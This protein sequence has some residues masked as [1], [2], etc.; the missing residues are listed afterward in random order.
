MQRDH[1]RGLDEIYA[2]DGMR[3]GR[4]EYVDVIDVSRCGCHFQ[5]YTKCFFQTTMDADGYYVIATGVPGCEAST[6]F[7]TSGV[8]PAR[9]GSL[10]HVVTRKAPP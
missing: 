9:T 7:A 3:D 5:P 6:L 10:G 1:S 2:T 8:D 4:R